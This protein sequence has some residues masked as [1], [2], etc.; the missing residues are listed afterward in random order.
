MLTSS[1]IE[2]LRDKTVEML[3]KTGI[4]VE[5]DELVKVMESKG[6]TA[7]PEGW[8]RIPSSLIDDFVAYQ[9]TTREADADDQLLVLDYGTDFAHR[10]IWHGDKEAYAKR[11]ASGELLI[12]AFDCGPTTLYDYPTHSVK[13]VGEAVFDDMMKL[14]EATPEI[15]YTSTWYRQDLPPQMERIDSL[16]RGIR[17]TSKLDGIES[18]FMEVIKYL[19]EASEI[20][21]GRPASEASYLAGSQCISPPLILDE[22]SANEMLERQRLGIKKYHIASMPSVGVNTPVTP[23]GSIVLGCAECLGGLIAA[24][25]L[26]PAGDLTGRMI[27]MLSDMRN[28][29]STPVGPEVQIITLG[30]KHVFDACWGGHCWVDVQFS[31]A[32]RR[33]GLQAVTEYAMGRSCY[34]KATGRYIPYPGMGTLHTGGLGSP[35]QLMLDLEIRKFEHRCAPIEVND[36]TLA[37]EE[38]CQRTLE[39]DD[40]LSADH[41]LDHFREQHTSPLFLTDDPSVGE[42]GGD[43]KAILDRCDEMWRENLKNWQPPEWPDDVLRALD[44]LVIR[45]KKEFGCD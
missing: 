28:A 8:V 25:C 24:Y 6:C 27:T 20:I 4:H 42:W 13:P 41:T 44:Q 17:L 2:M 34:A 18:I 36:E 9:E 21:T 35:T 22:R 1:Q 43:E 40:W 19:A 10:I 11:K 33:P 26:D 30:V 29:N 31:P 38:L 15:G 37:F 32:A 23:A 12:S 45:A 3:S 16:V 39:R 5:S 7:T 14:A